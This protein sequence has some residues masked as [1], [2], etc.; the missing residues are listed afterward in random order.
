M[1]VKEIR[2][3]VRCDVCKVLLHQE[4]PYGHLLHFDTHKDIKNAIKQ[5]GWIKENKVVYC[6]LCK[7]GRE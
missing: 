5:E 7:L 6:D 2:Y 1:I 4:I 3:Y